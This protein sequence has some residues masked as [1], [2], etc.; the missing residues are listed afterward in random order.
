MLNPAEAQFG[1]YRQR[2]GWI[3]RVEPKKIESGEAKLK[4]ETDEAV[5]KEAPATSR[6]APISEQMS[7]AD[8][9]AT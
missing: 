3:K 7:G 8:G 6:P 4:R 2:G 9:R 5:A 1:D